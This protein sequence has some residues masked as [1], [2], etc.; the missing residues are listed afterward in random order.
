MQDVELMPGLGRSS[1]EGNGSPVFMNTAVF[2][3]GESPGQR[4]PVDRS[5]W[6]RKEPETA[7]GTGRRRRQS[8]LITNS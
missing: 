3:P 7:E 6:G 5:R 1:G 8:L 2:L 4:S